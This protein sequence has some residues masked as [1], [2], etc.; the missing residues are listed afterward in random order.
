MRL[1]LGNTATLLAL[2]LFTPRE[3]LLVT[4]I[5]VIVGS[6][7]VGRLFA[8]SFLLSLCGGLAS[9]ATMSLVLRFFYPQ[10]SPVGISIF[11][12][13]A[14]NLAQLAVVYLLWVKGAQIL[15]LLPMFL[16]S[17]VATGFLTGALAFLVLQKLSAF[18]FSST[19]VFENI[20]QDM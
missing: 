11:G 16:L 12:A 10:F 14:H 20:V 13:L 5:R 9:L 8:P 1:G 19:P 6:L 3:A 18:G 17:S 2:F 15:F 7:I 4:L